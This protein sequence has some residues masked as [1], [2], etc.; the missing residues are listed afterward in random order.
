MEK[1]GKVK[2]KKIRIFAMTLLMVFILSIT[3]FA[4]EIKSSSNLFLFNEKINSTDEV[5][6]DLYGFAQDINIKSIVG[7]D[8]IS[9]GQQIDI[10]SKQVLGN[11]RGAGQ[12][13]DIDVENTR[14]ITVAGQEINIGKNTNA[15]AIYASGQSIN[16]K[17]NTNDLY[18]AGQDIVIDGTVNGNL[19]IEGEN[20]TITD[21]ANVLGSVNIKS[22]NEPVISGNIDSKDINYEK[23]VHEK[24]FKQDDQF[25]LMTTVMGIITAIIVALLLFVIFKNYFYAVEKNLNSSL[26][27]YILVGLG[28]LIVVPIAVILLCLTFIGIPIGLILLVLYILSMYLCPMITGITLGQRILKGQNQ[29]LQVVC[30]VVAIKLLLLVPFISP[31]IWFVCIMFTLGSITM[32]TINKISSK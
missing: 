3:V 11:I 2:V 19:G 14:N 6:G 18:L 30:G 24:S 23:I 5:K 25:N 17:G 32:K 31:I 22:S 10:N 8:I 12:S 9:L 26:G 20:I 27:K 13:I 21:K 1:R 4:D 15:N 28:V 16:F 7:G 29:Y